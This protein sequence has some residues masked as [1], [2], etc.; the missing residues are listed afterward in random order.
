[1]ISSCVSTSHAHAS[2][3]AAAA[4]EAAEAAA[5]DH[6]DPAAAILMAAAEEGK[7]QELLLPVESYFRQYPELTIAGE[8]E[9]RCRNGNDFPC[10]EAEGFYRVYGESGE[11]LMLGRCEAGR[12]YTIKSFFEV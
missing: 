5:E 4:A 12:M 11:F 10:R 2:A 7:A 1:M 9:R 6:T 8:K 3:Q